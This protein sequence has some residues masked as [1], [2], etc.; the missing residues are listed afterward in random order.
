MKS[1]YTH[2]DFYCGLS[3]GIS[4]TDITIM[5]YPC[6]CPR[7]WTPGSKYPKCTTEEQMAYCDQNRIFKNCPTCCTVNVSCGNVGICS[8]TEDSGCDSPKV[9]TN[10]PINC[11]DSKYRS[12]NCQ[13]PSIEEHTKDSCGE[14]FTNSPFIPIHFTGLSWTVLLILLVILIVVIIACSVLCYRNNSKNKHS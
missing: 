11:K 1:D 10:D 14:S 9:L 8:T 2:I 7:Y 5:S 6:T 13:D 3:N 4:M 12:N